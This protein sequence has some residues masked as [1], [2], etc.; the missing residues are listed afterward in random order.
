M[1]TPPSIA[2]TP[3]AGP[4]SLRPPRT[5]HPAHRRRAPVEVG[6]R[7]AAGGEHPA[8]TAERSSFAA[9]VAAAAD[10]DRAAWEQIVAQHSRLLWSVARGVGLGAADAADVC[11]TTWVQLIKH[12][13]SIEDPDRIGAWLVTTA[14]R[15]AIRL[16]RR[17]KRDL[18]ASDDPVLERTPPGLVIDITDAA[19]ERDERAVACLQGMIADL[20]ERSRLLLALLATDPTPSY[21]EISEVLDMPIGSIGPTRAR[22]LERLREGL[23]ALGISQDDVCSK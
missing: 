13:D 1:A 23:T 4:A 5:A 8:D 11:Q 2:D 16:S 19:I 18:P 14:R 20:P 6:H 15:E 12:L 22:A 10:G 17:T 9:L 3:A 21:A 7:R